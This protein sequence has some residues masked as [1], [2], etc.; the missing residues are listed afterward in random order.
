MRRVLLLLLAVFGLVLA[1]AL[2]A[3]VHAREAEQQEEMARLLARVAQ[4][5]P[6]FDEAFAELWRLGH[7]KQQPHS[8]SHRAGTNLEHFAVALASQPAPLPL[9]SFAL[10]IESA[11]QQ[12]HLAPRAEWR[13]PE[14]SQSP[15]RS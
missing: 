2:H 15:P 1:P 8:H 9:P 5:G 6:D 4:H 11:A 10:L 14:R 3:L 12:E 13:I 7:E